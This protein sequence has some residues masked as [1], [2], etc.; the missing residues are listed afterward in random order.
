MLDP[1][2]KT[3]LKSYLER[4]QR[5]IELVASVDEAPKSQE[6]MSLLRDIASLTPKVGRRWPTTSRP[7]ESNRRAG[8]MRTAKG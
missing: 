1:A 4:L 3:Q 8:W 7:P 6:L 2:L 5:P